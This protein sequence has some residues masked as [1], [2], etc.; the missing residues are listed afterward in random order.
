LASDGLDIVMND[1]P[2]SEDAL[3][4]VVKEIQATSRKAIAV[5]GDLS[6]HSDVQNLIDV[7]VGVWRTRRGEYSCSSTCQLI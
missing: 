6:S 4:A 5:T 7:T 3:D 2:S 1:L